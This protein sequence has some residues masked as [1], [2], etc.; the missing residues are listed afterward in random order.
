MSY[1]EFYGL[2]QEPF[3][4]APV[5]RFYYDA[6]QHSEALVRILYAIDSMKGLAVLVGPVGAGKTTLARR[7]LEALNENDYEAA[8]LVVIHRDITSDW[9]L[10]R[11]A[12]QLGVEEP[13]DNKLELLSQLYR[14]LIEIHESGKKAVVLVDEAQM[15]DS[16]ALMEEF[17]G[18]LNLEVPERKL[19]SFVFLGLPE[20][21]NNLRMDPPLLQRVALKVSLDP[22]DLS[23]TDAYVRH[24]LRLAG[25]RSPIFDAEGIRLVH[26][27]SGGMPRL[28]NTVCDNVL[29]EGALK[30][31]QRIGSGLIRMVA[32]GLG[33]PTD[34]EYGHAGSY[35]NL[36]SSELPTAVP[37]GLT[38]RAGTAQLSAPPPHLSQEQTLE[39]IDRVL[40]ALS[41]LN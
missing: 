41:R 18:L 17:R 7:I 33:L 27:A 4:N 5:S 11:I 15:L 16:R 12:L 9:L 37:H 34:P 40:Q 24:R 29:L 22:L 6:T 13:K 39:E 28:I 20:L 8:L 23:S 26:L 1:L 19:L 3:S 32:K 25:A 2:Q 14:R 31:Q 21:E 38:A 35:A 36:T 10:R 30:R